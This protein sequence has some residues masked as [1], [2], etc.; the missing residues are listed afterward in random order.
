MCRTVHRAPILRRIRPLRT[1]R[2]QKADHYMLRARI[3]M[4]SGAY[5]ALCQDTLCGTRQGQEEFTGALHYER[6]GLAGTCVRTC[7]LKGRN[8]R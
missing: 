5:V 3:K 8:R 2:A 4:R 7:R 1:L 6:Y